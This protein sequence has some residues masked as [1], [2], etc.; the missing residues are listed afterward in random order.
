VN[1]NRFGT[2]PF[3]ILVIESLGCRTMVPGLVG[4]ESPLH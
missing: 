1:S 3:Q 2:H 4:T